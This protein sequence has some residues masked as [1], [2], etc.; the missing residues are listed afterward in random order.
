MISHSQVPLH[1]SSSTPF[2]TNR[3]PAEPFGSGIVGRATF[4]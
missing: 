3:V 2:K 1:L 4:L